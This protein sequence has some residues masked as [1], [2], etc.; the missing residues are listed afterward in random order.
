MYSMGYGMGKGRKGREKRENEWVADHPTIDI[1]DA[2][3]CVIGGMTHN[4]I[5]RI[6]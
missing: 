2:G 4:S 3:S 6:Q 5:I 1:L